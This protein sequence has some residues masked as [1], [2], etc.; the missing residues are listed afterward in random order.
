MAAPEFREVRERLKRW[1]AFSVTVLGVVA[2]LIVWRALRSSE[3]RGVQRLVAS[4]SRSAAYE[5]ALRLQTYATNLTAMAARWNFDSDPER[6]RWESDARLMVASDTAIQALE[7][8]D[9]SGHVR[10][11]EPLAGNEPAL[12]FDLTSESRR[13]AALEKS[14]KTGKPVFSRTIDLVQGGK[15]VLLFA[16]IPGSDGFRGWILGV[17]RVGVLFDRV[18][19]R[20]VAAHCGVAVFDGTDEIFRRPGF[21]L[22]WDAEFGQDTPVEPGGVSWRLRAWPDTVLRDSLGFPAADLLGAAGLALSLVLGFL[23]Y[24]V[25]A[26]RETDRILR[27]SEERYRLLVDNANDIVLFLKPDGRIV[28]ANKEAVVAYGY[29]R[30]ELLERTVFDLRGDSSRELVEQ[31]MEEAFQHGALFMA[32]HRRKDGSRLDVEVS[33]RS[34][35]IG[36]DRILMS[37]IRDIS[38]RFRA[39][40]AL[41]NSEG[42]YRSVFSATADALLVFNRQSGQIHDANPAACQMY[43]YTREELQKMTLID[44]S[45]EPEETVRA[46][47]DGKVFV[48]VRRQR[49]R[50]GS[51]I[52]VEI[53]ARGFN[54]EGRKMGVLCSR[55][56]GARVA[57][58]QD[59]RRLSAAVEQV[60]E[61]VVITDTSGTILYVNPAFER[62]TGYTAA[63][64]KGQNPRILSSGRQ[65]KDFY[66]GL[67]N[68]LLSGSSWSGHF[69]NRRKNGG[70][71]EEEATIS[72]VR[73]SSGTV[74]N[75]VAVKR[76][77]TEE[78]AL[79]EQLAQ[80]QRMEAIGRLA[81]GVAHDFNNILTVIQGYGELLRA[82]LANDPE[83]SESM[84]E[85][86]RAAERA[87]AL[88]RQLLAFSRR[89]VLETRVLD[90][91][92]VVADIEKMLRRLIGEDVEVVVVRP[93]TLGHVKADPGQI[94]QVLLNLAVNSRDA[95]PGGGR[96]TVEL[97]DVSLDAP[98]TTSH[99]SIPSG[100]YVVVSVGDT[101]SGMDAET[102]S[103][104]FEP[105]FTTKEKGKGT[106]LGLATVFGI[107]KQSGG[108]VDVASAPGAGTTFRV[109]LPR[110]DEK[111]TSG[112]HPSVGSRRATET[113]LIVEDE[114]AVR[115]LVRAVLE[116]KG[117]AVLVAPD[118][119]A[120]LEL[121][122]K[123]AGVIDVLL[124]DVVMP[125][126]SGC[127]LAVL[128]TARRPKVKV[129]F[130]SGYTAG[131]TTKLGA[132]G[133]PAFLSKPFNEQA[134]TV[135]LREMLD[136]PP[137]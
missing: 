60:A 15:G 76:D 91:G 63:E 70:L 128:V 90:L 1:V 73:D 43:G 87:A 69:I 134:L 102:L 11:I 129:I 49:R 71:Y 37:T 112:T 93:A 34:I 14:R 58:E 126:M 81:G 98:M 68:T 127:D 125:G 42:R 92:A 67:W 62:T 13:R 39:E 86:I 16:P 46:L 51:E 6:S 117:Y 54:Q 106:G 115:N 104:I 118:G 4:Q 27:E 79:R 61:A 10:W 5:V 119:A 26:R 36:R 103:H 100:Q 77:I 95:M 124:T 132:E 8:I 47:K 20:Q 72:P 50:G 108:Y 84:G 130:M 45:A 105:F 135:K 23:I 65:T 59:V 25:L 28:E 29:S 18:L 122:E 137:T 24:V 12:G 41:R 22:R 17:F 30:E 110:S 114:A 111:T 82:S 44:L 7:R 136:T 83:R 80:A 66:S 55:D 3:H 56:I 109:Y 101:G 38:E 78:L 53:T 40:T 19:S 48:P 57:A 75:Y 94:E 21:D 35:V 31:Q 107:V 113:V 64:A 131:I 121:V 2:A 85:I 89:Q 9:P 120:A 52:Q 133:G 88:T 32:V 97:A 123:H 116:R 33:A 96:L 99:D 74:V